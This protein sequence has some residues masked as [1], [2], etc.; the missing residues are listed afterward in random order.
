L[1]LAAVSG[2][3]LVILTFVFHLKPG[4][5]PVDVMLTIMRQV[6]PFLA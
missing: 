4:T 2:I 1:G 6:W 5:P 3:G